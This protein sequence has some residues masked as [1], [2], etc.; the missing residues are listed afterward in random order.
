MSFQSFSLSIISFWYFF[1]CLPF[2][3][4]DLS[5]SS[6]LLLF[7]FKTSFFVFPT[8]SILIILRYLFLFYFYIGNYFSFYLWSF[9]LF[10]LFTS[11]SL[12]NDFLFISFYFYSYYHS[13]SFSFFVYVWLFILFFFDFFLRLKFLPFYSYYP[14]LSSLFLYD[15]FAFIPLLLFSISAFHSSNNSRPAR[16]HCFNLTCRL[17]EW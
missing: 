12:Q 1:L 10:F 4:F 9:F 17:H 15:Y 5:F 11:F 6:F 3:N 16:G 8:I 13:M 7:H 14:S 2:L